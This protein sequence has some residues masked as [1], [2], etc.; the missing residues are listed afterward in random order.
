MRNHLYHDMAASGA[1]QMTY[2]VSGRVPDSTATVPINSPV[3]VTVTTQG[4]VLHF[5]NLQIDIK[6]LILCLT[7]EVLR[8]NIPYTK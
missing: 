6:C 4:V 7:L 1:P 2:Q 3:A 8:P 5:T